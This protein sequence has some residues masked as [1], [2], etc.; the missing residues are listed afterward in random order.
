MKL[1]SSTAIALASGLIAMHAAAQG[2]YGATSTA[3]Q[4][5]AALPAQAAT[6]P[7]QPK[8]KLSSKAGKAIIELQT[9]VNANDVANI[10]AKLAAAQSLAQTNDDR[11]AIARLQLNTAVTAKNYTAAAAAVDAISASG[12]IGPVNIAGLYDGVGI[13][14]YNLK[15]F[16][17]AAAIFQKAA[18]LNPQ[19]PEPLKLMAE[20]LNAQG[21]RAEA[22]VA[23]L[24]AIQLTAAAGQ[25]PGEDMY[26]RA[27]RL[28]YDAKSPSAV[29][30][31][32]QWAAAYPSPDSWHNALAIYR[33]LD[34]PDP[35]SAL[36]ILRLARAT[37]SL[38]GTGDYHIYAFE[39]ANQAN[40][41]E[42]KSLI[43]EGLAA[44]KIKASDPI[45]QEIQ[46]ALKGKATPTAADLAAA[47]RGAKV[48]TAFIHVGDRYYGGGNY[49]KAAELYGKALA[50]GAD[51]NLSN[52]RIGE[53]LARAGDKAGATAALNKVG[54][55]LADIARFW[56]I[57]VQ[58]QA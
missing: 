22:S 53:A 13:E 16:A 45:V 34:N 9:A 51:A 11:Y 23:L 48:P 49:Q 44:G 1:V 33:N 26:K 58:R 31:G 28:A 54:G 20:A 39:A 25:K 6:Q 12:L 29:D 19:S 15:Q 32:R 2:N 43:A 36:D 42:A 3:P 52:L 8:I 10:P 41:G 56:L 21:Q 5:T 18:A 14:L 55:S 7:E 47:E 35:A 30:L 57:Y 50:K 4:Q 38:Q 46:G 40:Y 37:D 27:V 24:K 17:Q